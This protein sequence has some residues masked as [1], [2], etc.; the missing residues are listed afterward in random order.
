MKRRRRII[1]AGVVGVAAVVVLGL[2]WWGVAML[3]ASVGGL[4]RTNAIAMASGDLN[5]TT[6]TQ[7]RQTVPGPFWFFRDGA[8][9]SISPGYRLV[10]AVTFNGTFEGSCGGAPPPGTTRQC[11]PP[12]HTKTVILDYFSG[13]FVMAM[14]GP[15]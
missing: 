13:A 4:S 7:V 10:W 9:D 14:T 11:P 2:A 12:N 5:S 3:G 1:G 15:P 6:P 8:T